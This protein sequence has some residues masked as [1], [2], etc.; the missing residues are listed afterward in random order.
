MGSVK[1]TR[2]E[3]IA[4]A[5]KQLQ[6][7]IE[8]ENRRIEKYTELIK[9]SVVSYCK[10][11][12]S[13]F[14]INNCEHFT[15]RSYRNDAEWSCGFIYD[16]FLFKMVDGGEKFQYGH[17]YKLYIKKNKW[18]WKKIECAEQFLDLVEKGKV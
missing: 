11:I 12:F 4:Q 2:E 14:D 3:V 10:D 7:D 8:W 1:I 17:T 15:L 13:G 5:E 18:G 16:G 6:E 9:C